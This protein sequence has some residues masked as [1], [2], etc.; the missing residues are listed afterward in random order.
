MAKNTSRNYP[1]E[2]IE[3]KGEDQVVPVESVRP[4]PW[5]YNVQ[6]PEIFGKLLQSMRQFG[7]T[8]PIVARQTTTGI[9][10]IDGEHRWRAARELGMKKVRVLNLGAVDDARAK[11]LSVIFNELGGR[12]DEVR[13]AELLRE[14]TQDGVSV[15]DLLAVMPYSAA[16]LDMLLET[17]DFGYVNLSKEDS[18]EAPGTPEAG[19]TEVAERPPAKSKSTERK[20]TLTLDAEAAQALEEKLAR[21]DADQSKAV[22]TAVDAYLTKKRKTKNVGDAKT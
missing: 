10:I 15:D 9:E 20:I 2:N 11:Q 4:N 5:N 21:I 13:L 17:V 7:F 12:P 8:Q 16:E 14:V 22:I 3:F 19:H 18:R 6:T 1:V